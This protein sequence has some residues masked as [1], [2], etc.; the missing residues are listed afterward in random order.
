MQQI[1]AVGSGNVAPRK[2]RLKF[3]TSQMTGSNVALESHMGARSAEKRYKPFKKAD[4]DNAPGQN[5]VVNRR[6]LNVE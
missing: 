5:L 2:N 3:G 1:L 4:W 6:S